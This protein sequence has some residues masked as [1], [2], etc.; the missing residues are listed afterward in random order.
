M[1]PG[2]SATCSFDVWIKDLVKPVFSSGCPPDITQT[3]DPGNCSAVV[4]VP[5]PVVNDP[6]NEGYSVINSFNNSDNAS[7]TYPVGVTTVIGPSQTH[8]GMSQHACK[9]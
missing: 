9:K 4:N 3:N 6:C 2:N 7:G 5:K 1:E 8:P